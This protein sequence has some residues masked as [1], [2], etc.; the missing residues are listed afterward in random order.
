MTCD[1]CRRELLTL[2]V[3]DHRDLRHLA[4]CERCRALARA[5]AAEEAV[6]HGAIGEWIDAPPPRLRVLPPPRGRAERWLAGLG[7]AAAAGAALWLGLFGHGRDRASVEAPAAPLV[8]SPASDRSDVLDLRVG[9]G[10]VLT[11]PRP[12]TEATLDEPIAELRFAGEDRRRLHVIGRSPGETA[13]TLWFEGSA[14]PMIYELVVD[15]PGAAAPPPDAIRLAVGEA[16]T[17]RARA[18]PEAVDSFDDAV[19]LAELVDE[20]LVRIT[21]VGPGTTDVVVTYAEGP[22]DLWTVVVHP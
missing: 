1:D 12:V 3:A 9:R 21:A 6:L 16:S 10:L 2:A 22:P 18:T 17:A 14:K 19:V 20:D 15:L 4:T 13:L 8:Q 7:I 11:M 5:I